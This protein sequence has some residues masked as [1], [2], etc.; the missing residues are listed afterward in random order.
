MKANKTK[1]SRKQ[2]E[3]AERVV[4]IASAPN[5]LWSF[6]MASPA[7]EIYEV[8]FTLLDMVGVYQKLVTGE[9]TENIMRKAAAVTI[10]GMS[11][12]DS[13]KEMP[14]IKGMHISSKMLSELAVNFG[15]IVPANTNDATKALARQI[16]ESKHAKIKTTAHI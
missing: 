5:F 15:E 9:H 2:I 12:P 16:K 4:E 14:F 6:Y 10:M 8:Q 7:G 3:A 11:D 1:L 13:V